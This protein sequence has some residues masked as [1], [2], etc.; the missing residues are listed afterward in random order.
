MKFNPIFCLTLILCSCGSGK[1]SDGDP[2]R[3]DNDLGQEIVPSQNSDA[4]A[5]NPAGSDYVYC[6]KDRE[7]VISFT[8]NPLRLG[9]R[10]KLPTLKDK[11][12]LLLPA[13]TSFG[14]VVVSKDNYYIVRWN[15]EMMVDP[16]PL[17][18]PIRTA[19]FLAE[20]NTLALVDETGSMVILQLA[21]DG[22]VLSS[23]NAGP[24]F[25]DSGAN[26]VA[27]TLLPGYRF[28]LAL[29]NQTLV[30]TDLRAS[31]ARQKWTY[32]IMSVPDVKDVSMVT[33]VA[34][35]TDL[36]AMVA[37]GKL[38]T[39]NVKSKQQVT[40]FAFDATGDK[41]IFRHQVPHVYGINATT[42]KPVVAA[43][44]VDGSITEQPMTEAISLVQ[45]SF[46]R[47]NGSE[48][49]IVLNRGGDYQALLVRPS[50][51]F[52]RGKISVPAKEV[53]RTLVDVQGALFI[54]PSELGYAQFTSFAKSSEKQVLSGYTIDRR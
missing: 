32:E 3:L 49:A 53:T 36:V 35:S 27:G 2:V 40:V 42:K 16:E 51:Q 9:H 47:A 14:V 20:E 10:V 18:H 33:Y 6:D 45:Q 54:A 41:K 1:S 31:M 39:M 52:V 17:S 26:I 5:D 43:V 46:L 4:T 8:P 15:G 25:V 19:A 34:G 21:S 50:D 38:V 12:C 23:W 11:E 48:A 22:S 7:E 28:V 24:I 13:Q 29:D 37:E 44:H 30:V